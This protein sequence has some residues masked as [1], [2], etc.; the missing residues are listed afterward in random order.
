[1]KSLTTFAA[2]LA[3]AITLTA[4]DVLAQSATA[5]ERANCNASFKGCSGGGTAAPFGEMGSGGLELL[6][7]AAVIL[8][9]AFRPVTRR[10]RRG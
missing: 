8:L 1:M 9:L 2:A 3:A 4:G 10:L 6:V 5:R 7:V